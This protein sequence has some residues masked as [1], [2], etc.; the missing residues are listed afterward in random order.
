MKNLKIIITIL[1]FV[2][3]QGQNSFSQYY[4]TPYD[5]T[6]RP[7]GMLSDASSVQWNPALLG[8]RGSADFLIGL[9]LS[10]KF[11]LMAGQFDIFAKIRGIGLGFIYDKY[12]LNIDSL[13]ADK[14]IFLGGGFPV[15]K[16]QMWWGA[17]AMLRS[18]FDNLKFNLRSF[19]YNTSVVYTPFSALITSL[20]ASNMY[21]NFE[22]INWSLG[23][24]YSPNEWL[25]VHTNIAYNPQGLF[26]GHSKFS[27]DV[28]LSFG[29]LS[30]YLIAS[31][32][33]KYEDNSYRLG[34][35]LSVDR[36]SFGF[37]PKMIDKKY[38]GSTAYFRLKTEKFL[39]SADLRNRNT[40][41]SGLSDAGISDNG[42]RW[43]PS[44]NNAD[45]ARVMDILGN[46]GDK[47]KDIY[48]QLKN[49]GNTQDAFKYIANRYYSE[50]KLTTGDINNTSIRTPWKY[51]I[52][53][54]SVDTL[55]D[56]SILVRLK[57][58]DEFGRDVPNLGKKDFYL[59]DNNYRI[60][61]VEETDAKP[62]QKIDLV[63]LQDCSTSLTQIIDGVKYSVRNFVK[64]LE[65]RGVDYNIGGILYGEQ[66]YKILQPTDDINKF[67]KFY[68]QASA[69]APDEVSSIAIDE[70]LRLNFRPNAA[71]IFIM[72]TDEATFQTNSTVTEPGLIKKMWDSSATIYSIVNYKEYNS[73]LLTRLTLGKEYN[74]YADLEENL[75]N[76]AGDMIANYT[77]IIKPKEKEKEKATLLKG[78]CRDDENWKVQAEL[79]FK[80]K[81]GKTYSCN[82]NPITGYYEVELPEGNLY[83]AIAKSTQFEAINAKIDM[84]AINK[85]DTLV[86]DF[87]FKNPRTSL[88]GT[89][90]GEN[91][92]PIS[93]AEITIYE[94]LSRTP[95]FILATDKDGKYY[96]EISEGKAYTVTAKAKNYIPDTKEVDARYV[97]KGTQLTQ[98]FKLISISEAVAKQMNIKL[99]YV[100]FDSGK[101]DIKEESFN[102]LNSLAEFLKENPEVRLEVNAHTDFV[103]TDADNQILSDNRAA[104]VVTYLAGKGIDKARMFSKGYGESMPIAT[105]NTEEGRSM[106]RRVEF[107]LLK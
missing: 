89:V 87:I 32:G 85:G 16:N 43:N 35:E 61:L 77:V 75:N 39:N 66:I 95:L 90:I 64:S 81:S 4:S 79:T 53:A 47:Y 71:K 82:S 54:Q 70:A 10:N 106:N 24:A 9:P 62:K 91:D 63:I 50:K 19:R 18:T 26:R 80:D 29:G 101:Y 99:D 83:D 25:T 48:A 96:T 78:T 21:N 52:I 69:T 40:I 27:P 37:I 41:S 55:A 11:G 5:F 59:K 42:Y 58:K 97:A 13:P 30:D 44:D 31:L 105:N 65:T 45:V 74:I 17:S 88:S 93:N 8:V 51:N 92:G 34:V 28:Y 46:A 103:G 38:G 94:G 20:G 102:G 107:K 86:Y 12:P 76:I 60:D 36:F 23:A 72:L 2:I 1:L 100:F 73:G 57:V 14:T 22:Y 15:L 6:N 49:A 67:I 3:L 84:A 7:L 98:N 68:A 104:S 56:N 33:Y